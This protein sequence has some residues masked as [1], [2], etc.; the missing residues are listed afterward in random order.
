MRLLVTGSAGHLGEA[1]MRTLRSRGAP[2]V[3]LDHRPSEYTDIVAS[4]ADRAAVRAALDGIDAVIHTATLHKPH[5]ATHTRQDFIDTN[6]T[7]T[8]NLL[9]ASAAAGVRAFVFSSSTSVFGDALV[10]PPGAP[11]AWITEDVVPL[12]KNIYGATKAAAEDLCR[13]A[14]RNQGLPCVVLRVS[15]F[16]PEPDDDPATRD[17]FDDVNLKVN[18]LL[19][20]RVALDDVVSAHLLATER[21]P[22]LGFD[23]FIVSATP[24]FEPGDASALR[25]DA[26]AVLWRRLPHAE[27]IY[28]R[29]GW[30][31]LPALDRVYDNRRARE[32]LGWQP[33]TDFA[34]ALDAIAAGG[35]GQSLL[36]RQVG[37][38]GYHGAE[39]RRGLYPTARPG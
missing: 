1:L 8:L 33:A 25:A 9:D 21:A 11:A 16:F 36:V 19:Y 17:A 6:V 2:V 18:E 4:V 34:C 38:K 24:P 28:R 31:M 12:A 39:H 14:H 27:A 13:L 22:H 15:R 5:V 30:R 23:R 7:G 29:L 20:R 37:I 32:V 35:D 10:P 26:P 3:G